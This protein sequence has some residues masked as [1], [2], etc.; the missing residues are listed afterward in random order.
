MKETIREFL[1]KTKTTDFSAYDEAATKQS[2][3]LPLLQKLGWDIFNRDE[4]YPEYSIETRKVDYSLRINNENKVFLEAKKTSVNLDNPEYYEQLLGYSFQEGVGLSIL[5]NGI[6]WFFFL[7][8]MEGDWKKRKIYTIDIKEQDSSDASDKFSDLLLKDN[9]KSGD[10][11]RHAEKIYKGKL[12]ETNIKKT[13]P[14]AWNNLIEE[15]DSILIDLLSEATERICGYKPEATE[16]ISFLKHNGAKFSFNPNNM[17]FE[18]NA[19]IPKK[20]NSIKRT[21]L[22]EAPTVNGFEVE[23]ITQ[24]DLIPYIVRALKRSNGRAPKKQVDK[25]IFKELEEI[26]KLPYYQ[27]LVANNKVPRWKHNIAWAR[28]HAQRQ[29]LIKPPLESGRGVWELTEEG[30]KAESD[31]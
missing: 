18:E 31:S 11:L 14:E 21:P 10:S 5:T 6:T 9:I 28:D 26:F 12:K 3:I 24:E 29:G 23:K 19:P 13:L 16:V 27:E 2:I 1:E 20:D 30:R 7:P 25:E 22:A 15:P 17:D 8:K 4:V